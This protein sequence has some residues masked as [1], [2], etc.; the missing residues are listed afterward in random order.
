MPK[1]YYRNYHSF[2]LTAIMIIL[3]IGI[4]CLVGWVGNIVQLIYMK[5]ILNG[6]GAARIAGIPVVPLGVILGW[7][8]FF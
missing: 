4:F 5:E 2:G 7:V 3:V 1:S 6:M 8:G